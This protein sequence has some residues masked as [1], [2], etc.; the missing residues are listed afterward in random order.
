VV[1][2]LA[3]LSHPTP[4][5][6]ALTRRA[7]IIQRRVLDVPGHPED[8]RLAVLTD[9]G[10]HPGYVLGLSSDPCRRSVQAQQRGTT[11]LCR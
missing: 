3:G 9:P 6:F 10:C 5:V 2:G 4:D 8:D 7:A 1:E 11:R